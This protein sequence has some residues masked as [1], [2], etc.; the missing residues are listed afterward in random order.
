M[1]LLG[2]RERV[3]TDG[4]E[5]SYI[6]VHVDRERQTVDLIPAVGFGPALEDVPF[7]AIRPAAHMQ[8]GQNPAARPSIQNSL[9]G[10]LSPKR[11]FS[12]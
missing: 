12:Q 6:I 4:Q 9:L 5:D 11:Q 1:R 2:T 10:R 7:R 3:Q 8:T